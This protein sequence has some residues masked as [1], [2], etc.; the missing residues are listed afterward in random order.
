M[1]W[2][3]GTFTRVHDWTDDEAGGV[4]ILSTRMDEE[5]DNFEAGINACLT[6]DGSNS[7]S[8]N[9]PMGGMRHTGAGNGTD[10]NDYTLVTQT[11]NGAFRY[12]V[13]GGSLNAFT[14]TIA[15]TPSGY[16]AGQQ[17]NFKANRS[18][19]GATTLNVNLLG[20]KNVYAAGKPCAGG[21]IVVGYMYSVIYDGTQ[22]H[23]LSGGGS[24]SGVSLGGACIFL[25]S[26]QNLPHN[27]PMAIV[28]FRG[29]AY[30]DSG[31][32]LPG[33]SYLLIPTTAR[34]RITASVPVDF[35]GGPGY[36]LESNVEAALYRNGS[37]VRSSYVAASMYPV[38]YT[39]NWIIPNF[40]V[41]FEGPLVASDQ[42]L[43]KVRQENMG[44]YNMELAGNGIV[45]DSCYMAITRIS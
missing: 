37:I 20:A 45:Y 9:L 14:M 27:D 16:V 29:E 25:L 15:P 31:Y 5:D 38:G 32:Y 8:A 4:D 33:N 40:Q 44:M 13:T 3:G 24:G 26:P 22:F 30:D 23:L 12:G 10:L 41:V 7:P 43:L 17:F 1:G 34:Y 11:Q 21:E 6:K 35:M 28:G 18:N 2:S 36:P 42:I 19:S 39:G